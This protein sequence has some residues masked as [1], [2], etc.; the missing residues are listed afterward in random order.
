MSYSLTGTFICK[1]EKE[2]LA[3]FFFVSISRS[4]VN[5]EIN[6]VSVFQRS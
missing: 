6:I 1:Q 4:P 2:V 5:M 3:K